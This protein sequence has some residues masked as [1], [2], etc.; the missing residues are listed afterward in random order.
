[1]KKGKKYRLR[2]INSSVDN[3]IRVSLDGHQF[4]VISSDLIPIKPYTTNWVLLATGQRYDVIVNANQEIGNYWFRAEAETACA[5]ASGRPGRAIFTYE[6][7]TFADPTTSAVTKPA[8]CN[9]E[10]PLV[11]WV[12][13]TVGSSQAFI[14]QAG[15][16]QVNLAQEQ[17]TTNGQNVVVWAVNL[18]A[19]S[20]DSFK[21]IL[22]GTNAAYRLT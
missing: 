13:N 6:T 19:V 4:Q 3:S 17:L 14:E 18:T 21:S 15:N 20:S 22:V 9:D 5:S 11:P 2:L 1:M 8:N 16:L 10:S 12:A 7:A